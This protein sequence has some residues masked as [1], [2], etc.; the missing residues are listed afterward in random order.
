MR[1]VGSSVLIGSVASVV[2]L[3]RLWLGNAEAPT[4]VLWA[5]DGLFPICV[6]KAGFLPCLVDPFAGYLLLAPRLVAGVVAPLPA[7]SWALATNLLAAFLLGVLCATVFAWARR[8]GAGTVA[9]AV[10]GLLPACA[11]LVGLEAINA[12]GSIYMPMLYTATILVCLQSRAR[13]LRRNASVA[14]G[15]L[16]LLTALTIPLAAL[17]VLP[18]LVHALRRVLAPREAALWIAALV[19][20]AFVQVLTAAT[21]ERPREITIGLDSVQSFF[22]VLPR[23]VLTY[24]PGL[25]VTPYDYDI[26]FSVEPVPFTGVVLAGLLILAGIALL[27]RRT[28]LGLGAGMMVLLG[29]AFGLVPTVIGW[30]N[31]R[32]FVVP[33][34]LWGAVAVLLADKPMRMWARTR[35]RRLVLAGLSVVLLFVWWPMVPASAF[36]ST[37]APP[38]QG[39]VARVGAHCMTDPTIQERPIFTPF[40]PPNWGDGLS[41]PTHPNFP[42]VL[43]WRWR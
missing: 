36:R 5:E 3:G 32:Y 17:L 16:L 40:W 39:E 22:D 19:I 25:I 41:E 34:L 6:V 42:C 27:H 29:L 1:L 7:A 24:W 13:P 2:S 8:W 11:P 20:G 35:T 15:V 10:A 4:Q 28:D 38:W 14:V 33:V 30:A 26:N 9:A 21:A 18:I 23:S 12:L 43:A 31:N 37:P